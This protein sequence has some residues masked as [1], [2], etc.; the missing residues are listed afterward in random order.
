MILLSSSSFPVSLY[1]FLSNLIY[2]TNLF[3]FSSPISYHLR[4]SRFIF[5]SQP[6]NTFVKINLSFFSPNFCS[7]P[8]QIFS[9]F[10]PNSYLPPSFC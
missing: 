1:V 4:P 9:I 5:V 10:S 6:Q 2:E 7:P 3:P 8:S